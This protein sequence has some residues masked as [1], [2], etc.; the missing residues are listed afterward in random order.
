M[1][2]SVSCLTA[3]SGLSHPGVYSQKKIILY[4]IAWIR[5]GRQPILAC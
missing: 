3:P 5:A 1:V 4:R 2:I